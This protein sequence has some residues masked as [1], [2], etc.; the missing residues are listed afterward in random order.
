MRLTTCRFLR[1]AK[2]TLNQLVDDKDKIAILHNACP[3][4]W[5]DEQSRTNQLDLDLQ[6]LIRY[7][8]TLKSIERDDRD[9]KGKGR[10]KKKEKKRKG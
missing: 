2:K 5:C 4:S 10:N 8:S 1:Y 3:R 6:E 7:Y 9:S